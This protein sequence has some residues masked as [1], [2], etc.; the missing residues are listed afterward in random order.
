M[1]TFL[2]VAA[3]LFSLALALP[4][5]QMA[6]GFPPDYPLAGVETTATRPATG[7]A[8]WWNGT[9]Q[10]DF[11][12]WINQRIGLRGWLVRTANQLNYV[13]F[14]ELPRRSGTQVLLGRDGMLY[15]KVYVDAYNQSGHRL[16]KELRNISA[17]T[18]RL[19]DRLAADGIAFLLV[20]AP[21]KAE[22]YPEFLPPEADVAGRPARRS[23]YENFVKYLRAD[24][25]NLVDAHELFLQWK[26]APDTP[27]MF[28]NGGTHW[29]EYGAARV[30]AEIARRLRAAT[31][32]DLPTV[33]IVGAATNRTIVG[34]DNDLGELVNL[35][36]GRPLAGPQVHPVVDVRPGRDLPDVLFVGD[37]FVFTL[38]N[39]MDR[40]GL[41]RKRNTY[42]YY[43]REYFWPAAPNA[44]LDKRQLDLLA[45]VRG[46]DA[47]VIEVGE[48][49][50]PRVGFG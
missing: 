47:V 2:L 13:L 7:W 50:L 31:G 12:G 23:N 16:G 18:K 43:N 11:D 25:V 15:E 48:Y 22:I 17:S 10:P 21:S 44:P 5:V 8:A 36:S 1:K 37:S 9:L 45:E 30:V 19:Q 3:I 41:Y 40:H 6:T 33:E 4:L 39:F 14:R 28:A 27:R 20:I 42:Y 26:T 35:W 38:T 34:E 46:R 32:K 29:N 24:G 49:W